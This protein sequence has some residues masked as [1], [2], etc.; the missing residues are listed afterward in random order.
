MSSLKAVIDSGVKATS[1]TTNGWKSRANESYLSVTCH[2]MDSSFQLHVQ[3]LACTEM[4]DTHTARN[5]V[6]FLKSIMEE[7]ALPDPGTVPV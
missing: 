3:T 6:L 5:L 1:I 7:W 2:V 4:A